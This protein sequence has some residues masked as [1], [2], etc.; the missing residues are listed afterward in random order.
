[1]YA[2]LKMSTTA[3]ALILSA[4]SAQAITINGDALLP[5]PAVLGNRTSIQGAVPGF[6]SSGPVTVNYAVAGFSPLQYWPS[7]YSGN[8]AAYCGG[9]CALEL[10]VTAGNTVTLKDFSLGG[11]LNSDRNITW[12]V[13]D[14]FDASIIASAVSPL[15]SGVTGLLNPINASSTAGFHIFFGPDGFN[16]GI[17]SVNYSFNNPTPIPLPAAGLLLLAG[18]GGLAA[19]RRRKQ[20]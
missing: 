4:A 16:G 6:G 11:W 19:L 3:L 18:L 5:I 17:T 12:S 10:T 9:A 14:L 15:V 20:A 1:M 7:D 8:S 13:V 2:R